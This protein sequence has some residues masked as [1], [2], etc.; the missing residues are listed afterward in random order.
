MLPL[1]KRDNFLRKKRNVFKLIVVFIFDSKLH[2]LGSG[3]ESGLRSSLFGGL[4]RSPTNN[5]T[6]TALVRPTT[7]TMPRL[8]SRLYVTILKYSTNMLI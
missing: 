6:G 7:F 1:L 4:A 2:F 8:T 3:V 5:D